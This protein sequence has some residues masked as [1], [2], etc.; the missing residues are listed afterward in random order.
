MRFALV[1]IASITWSLTVLRWSFSRAGSPWRKRTVI[2]SIVAGVAALAS[3]AGDARS[4]WL[5]RHAPDSN[6]AI[7]ITDMGD[8]WRISYRRGARACITANEIH[9]PAGATVLLT[10]NAPP[11][12][13]WSSR[14]VLPH[15][16][17]TFCFVAGSAGVD[18]V[19]ILRLWPPSRRHL[20]VVAD[21]PAA[22]DRWFDNEVA[23][24]KADDSGSRAFVS[25][26]CAY[27]HVVRGVS[28]S[29]WKIAPELTH[30]GSRRTIASTNLPNEK[31]FLAGWIV[32]SK[33]LKSRSA[34][35]RNA[36]DPIV[37]RE[38]VAYLE[39]LR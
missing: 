34:M 27:C 6:V 13:A 5:L 8:W 10:W 29:P 26:G 33:A 17:G 1:A 32:N 9:V 36:V 25:A 21:A 37:L 18:D 16:D 15:G 28:E 12:A 30:F 39:S 11:F 7:G 38:L 24:A 20:R 22:F 3:I 31:G 2:V 35:P 23:P 19:S 14:N 4:I